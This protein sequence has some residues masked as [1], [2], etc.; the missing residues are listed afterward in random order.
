MADVNEL[1]L[2]KQ[3]LRSA[4]SIGASIVEALAGISKRDFIAKMAIAS[5]ES[6][7]SRYWLQLIDQAELVSIDVM[8][9]LNMVEE[10]VKIL[11]KIVKTSASNNG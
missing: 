4:T 8:K 9:E 1:V 10:L 3:L 6:R 5:K 11:T 2:S 7:E